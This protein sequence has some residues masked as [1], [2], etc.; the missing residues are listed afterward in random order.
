MPI[1]HS[2]DLQ[3]FCF[4]HLLVLYW[5]RTEKLRSEIEVELNG[6]RL[7]KPLLG[8]EL[9]SGPRYVI[10]SVVADLGIT[11]SLSVSI[12]SADGDLLAVAEKKSPGQIPR[13]ILDGWT[14]TDRSRVEKGLLLQSRRMF[15]Q[16]SRGDWYRAAACLAEKPARLQIAPDL[17]CAYVRIPWLKI[18]QPGLLDISVRVL[19]PDGA[20]A[21]IESLS[22]LLEGE[23][24]HIFSARLAESPKGSELIC[25]VTTGHNSR[26]LPLRIKLPAPSLPGRT[27]QSWIDALAKRYPGN[28]ALLRGY[29]AAAMAARQQVAAPPAV[30]RYLD[31]TI[32]GIRNGAVT[33]WARDR[34]R[35]HL[36]LRL[37]VSIDGNVRGHTVA[38][39]PVLPG[40]ASGFSWVIPSDLLDGQAHDVV[41]CCAESHAQVPGSPLRL[42]RGHFDGDIHLEP[43][44]ELQGW[45]RERCNSPRRPIIGLLIDGQKLSDQS[46]AKPSDYPL[47]ETF[48]QETGDLHFMMSCPDTLF[49]TRMHAVQVEVQ[50]DADAS[51]QRIEPA[52]TLQARYRGQLDEHDLARVSGWIVNDIAPERAVALDML[53]NSEVVAK[54]V[55][56]LPRR[57]GEGHHGFEF[58]LPKSTRADQCQVVEIRLA[59]SSY[60]L[61]ARSLRAAQ[62]PVIQVIGALAGLLNEPDL[63][64]RHPVMRALDPGAVSWVRHELLVTLQKQLRQSAALPNLLSLPITSTIPL[65]KAAPREATIDVIIPVHGGR[66]A[67]VRCLTSVLCSPNRTS[68]ALIVIDD[69]SPD[70]SLTA[71]LR[72]LAHHHGF[73]LLENRS[74]LGFPA[75]VNRGMRLHEG[76]DVVLLNSDTRVA[77]GWLDRL[78][79]AAH[80]AANIGTVTAMSNNA[81]I[82]SF[83]W[84]CHINP[85]PPGQTVDTLDSIFAVINAG[86]TVD[87]PTAVGFCMY[88]RRAALDETGYFDDAR[89]GKGYAE[90]NDFCLRASTLGWRHVAACDVFVEHEG[91]ISF[92]ESSIPQL[93]HNLAQLNALYPDYEATV[94]AFIRDDPLRV[95]RHAVAL[96]IFKRNAPRYIVFVLH[97]LG[98]GAQRAAD[99]LGRT[100]TRQG[101]SVLQL[102]SVRRDV[103]TL[104][105]AELPYLIRYHPNQYPNLIADLKALNVWHIHYH[106][107]M[108]FP[109]R[110]WDLPADLG[111]AYDFTLHDYLPICPRINMI[112]ETGAYCGNAQFD[113]LICDGCIRVNG[114]D[115]DLESKYQAFGGSVTAW[116]AI[117]GDRLGKAR[118]V[119]APSQA[120]ADTLLPHFRLKNLSVKPH[121]EPEQTIVLRS[122]APE[123]TTVLLLGAL[124]DYKG[125]QQL[126]RCVQNAAKRDLPLRFVVIGYTRDDEPLLKYGNVR[127]TGEYQPADLP[128]LIDSIGATIALFLSPWPE[129][130]SYT[131]S[132]A[133]ANGLYPIALDIGAI[134]ERIRHMNCGRLLPLETPAGVINDILLEELGQTDVRAS[135]T[136]VLGVAEMNVLADY[137][138]LGQEG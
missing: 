61:G 134:A 60:G 126:C 26:C 107:T 20:E 76:R 12:L 66:D 13:S 113:P 136:R 5:Q 90:E 69:A 79:R 27:V 37:Q 42:G 81:S 1:P 46:Q 127:I 135:P 6:E 72:K 119:F 102:R 32:T 59:G 8:I 114:L 16:L 19:N 137:Y 105:G 124:A 55:A 130:Y 103:W 29:A 22:A 38:D 131:L 47:L 57:S 35:P 34:E 99:D 64:Q 39:M 25:L 70:P 85:L 71:E 31:G 75:T 7:S 95:A 89:W 65:P 74:N 84:F 33:G 125:Y 94:Q 93:N 87:L 51:R 54:A 82:C 23:T 106:Q 122:P 77:P 36:P 108:D 50:A 118:R 63:L 48:S 73:L 110:I 62:Q 78:A 58:C 14:R 111:L 123:V 18:D 133:W 80:S 138:D 52:L 104:R 129:T 83:P 112:D 92:G 28:S 49:D 67:V 68:M 45:V 98:G 100:L 43:N 117:Y 53:L 86:V 30:I 121:L 44:G 9:H 17:S 10:A 40:P 109:L 2:G 21:Y 56:N 115:H 101:I 41:L 15:P 96:E 132:E 120:A 11:R 116:R 128:G 4:G 91:G 3:I 88:I 97:G 24:L